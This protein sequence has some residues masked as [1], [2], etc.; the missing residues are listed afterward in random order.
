MQPATHT[1]VLVHGAWHGGWAWR[2]VADL[3]RSRGH[4]VYT[5]T[6]T[7]LGERS[8]LLAPGITLDTF[9]ADIVGVLEA[10]EL[11]DVILVGHS[12]GAN[13]ISGAADRAPARVRR[14]VYV[15]SIIL[16]HG[17][18]GFGVLPPEVAAARRKLVAERGGGLTIPPPDLA[19]LGIPAD[20][21]RAAWVQRRMTPQPVGTYEQPLVLRHP[22]ANGRPCTYVACT[23]PTYALAESTR[24]FAR[25]QGWDWHE[26]AT[27]H[28][29]MITAPEALAQ[30]LLE[31]A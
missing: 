29:A 21:P 20:H 16:Q 30:L 11:T 14:L 24:R 2:D 10:E 8:H 19:A 3:L 22:L 25:Q 23:A 4:R 18:S 5:P 9:I 31:I 6:Q 1:Y 12:F 17:Q 13:S 28:D 27:G 7:G 15:D 26:L